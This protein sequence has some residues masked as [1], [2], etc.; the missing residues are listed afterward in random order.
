[1]YSQRRKNWDLGAKQVLKTFFSLKKQFTNHICVETS[2]VCAKKTP[3]PKK[4]IWFFK[5]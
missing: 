2:T 5:D 1:M 4:W 3:H